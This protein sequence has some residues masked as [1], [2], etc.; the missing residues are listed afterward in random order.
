MEKISYVVTKDK[1]H[2]LIWCCRDTYVYARNEK[3]KIPCTTPRRLIFINLKII[4]QSVPSSHE[5][6]VLQLHLHLITNNL[7]DISEIII[8]QRKL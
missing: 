3:K 8:S 6:N 1:E 7:S 4:F 5:I 2:L